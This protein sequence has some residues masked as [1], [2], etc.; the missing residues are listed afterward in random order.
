MPGK[1]PEKFPEIVLEKLPENVLE[2][3]PDRENVLEKDVELNE[4]DVKLNCAVGKGVRV[5]LLCTRNVTAPAKQAEGVNPARVWFVW[6]V[7]VVVE[8]EGQPLPGATSNES[9]DTACDPTFWMVTESVVLESDA[10]LISMSLWVVGL[11]LW[12]AGTLEA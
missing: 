4:W 1:P 7:V 8:A 12:L 9:M 5:L 2:K 10:L 11:T 3:F 6:K